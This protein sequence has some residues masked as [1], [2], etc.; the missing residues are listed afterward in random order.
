MTAVTAEPGDRVRDV[1]RQE[2]GRFRNGVK[3]LAQAAGGV[4]PRSAENWLNGRATP[5]LE[6]LVELMANCDAL[7]AEISKIVEARK[8][9][10]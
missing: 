9:S 8:C 6:S 3:L 1:L 5:Q 4:S 7:A 2:F 10:R